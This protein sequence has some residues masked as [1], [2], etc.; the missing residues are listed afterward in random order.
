VGEAN[1]TR[2]TKKT[3][4]SYTMAREYLEELARAGLVEEIK[5]GRQRIYRI[6]WSDTRIR[7]LRTLIESG[8]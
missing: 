8:G 7:I 3:R 6:V 1:I 5:I 2:I 4:T